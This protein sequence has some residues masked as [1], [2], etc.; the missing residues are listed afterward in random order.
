M[1][2]NLVSIDRNTFTND[3]WLLLILSFNRNS[4]NQ[5]K[6]EILN[7]FHNNQEYLTTVNKQHDWLA[8]R[9]TMT[10]PGN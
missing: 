3:S 5:T 2:Q 4:I 9:K 7:C 8:R 6:Q 10:F 1:I